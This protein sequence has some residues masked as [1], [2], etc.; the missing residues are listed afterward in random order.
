MPLVRR[1]LLAVVAAAACSSAPRGT[2]RLQWRFADGRDCFSAGATVVEA[3]ARASLDSATLATFRC[4]DGLAPAE[5]SFDVPGSGTLYVDARTALGGDLYHG[6][7]AID[8]A[9]PGTGELRAVT[10]Y[11]VA[12]Q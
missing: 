1:L 7:L 4:F 3:R 8:A 6:E 11:A 12:A 2:L 10:L 5:V 9:P